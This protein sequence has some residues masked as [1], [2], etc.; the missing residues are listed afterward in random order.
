MAE[1]FLLPVEGIFREITILEVFFLDFQSLKCKTTNMVKDC[2]D[3]G[4]FAP[5]T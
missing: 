3:V 2:R 4:F 5:N 1:P